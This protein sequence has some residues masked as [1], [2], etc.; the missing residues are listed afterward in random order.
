MRWLCLGLWLLNVAYCFSW[1]MGASW[2]SNVRWP[3]LSQ[4]QVVTQVRQQLAQLQGAPLWLGGFL[5]KQQA[6]LLQQRLV[7]LDVAAALVEYQPMQGLSYLVY[8]AEENAASATA[9][10]WDAAAL[11]GYRL[12]QDCSSYEEAVRIQQ[13]LK[14]QGVAKTLIREQVEQRRSYWLDI[15]Q[16]SRG[17]LDARLVLALFHDYPEMKIGRVRK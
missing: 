7:S 4:Q 11:N 10:A 14:Q 17:V 5:E 12:W 13:Q 15:E 9:P 8:V 16:R 3:L 6:E 2:L 1:G